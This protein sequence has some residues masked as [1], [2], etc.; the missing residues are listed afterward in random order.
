MR[1]CWLGTQGYTYN[2]FQAGQSAPKKIK[3]TDLV[4]KIMRVSYNPRDTPTTSSRQARVQPKI[5]I[6]DLV[7]ENNES[8]LRT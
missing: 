4:G 7:G 8:W 3:F 6:T 5:K 2:I 1:V